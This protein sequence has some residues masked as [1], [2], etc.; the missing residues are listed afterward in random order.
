VT[1]VPCDAL[2]AMIGSRLSTRAAATNS[3][4]YYEAGPDEPAA[5]AA[6]GAALGVTSLTP[7]LAQPAQIA[8]LVPNHRGIQ[9]LHWIRDT[10]YRED[11]S[12]TRT[13]SPDPAHEP[14]HPEKSRH[15]S[16]PAVRPERHHRN[17]TL[18]TPRHT[19]PIPDPRP[20]QVITDLE[21]AVLP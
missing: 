13:R 9:S 10:L 6:D 12:T 20:R 8:E 7:T 15:R 5:I 11:D 3:T 2:D 18:G 14:W 17:N 19:P 1:G 4:A 16:H 21:T